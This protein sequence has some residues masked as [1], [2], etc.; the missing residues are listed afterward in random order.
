[1]AEMNMLYVG[2]SWAVK[3]FTPANYNKLGQ[4]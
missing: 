2:D 3:G 1:M 4:M